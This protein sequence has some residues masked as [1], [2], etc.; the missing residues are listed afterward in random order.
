MVAAKADRW[1]WRRYL[2][3]FLRVDANKRRRI[4]VN[5]VLMRV[6]NPST[7]VQ[8]INDNIEPP[9]KSKFVLSMQ[10]V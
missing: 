9:F 2:A 3:R 8:L 10:R 7:E 4:M 1:V 5:L 6:R